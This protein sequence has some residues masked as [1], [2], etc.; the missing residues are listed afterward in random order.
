MQRG[1]PVKE[2]IDAQ[3]NQPHIVRFVESAS[4]ILP[5]HFIAIEQEL[6]LECR[7]IDSALF[8]LIAAHFVFNIEYNSKVK[9][10]LYYFQDK[11]LGLSDPTFKQSSMY[12]NIRSAVD[13][14]LPEPEWIHGTTL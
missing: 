14:Y 7:S 2:A 5:N 1:T 13:L 10:V 6:V 4:D 3:N 12:R 8:L 11:V 9:D